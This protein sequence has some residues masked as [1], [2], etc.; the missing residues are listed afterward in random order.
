MRRYS[1]IFFLLISPLLM[2]CC[3]TLPE[4]NSEGIYIMVYDY[5]NNALKDVRIMLGDEEL[6]R[7]DIYGR[8]ILKNNDNE[9]KT[10]IFTKQGYENIKVDINDQRNQVLYIKLGSGQYYA[11]LS[12]Q[13][14]D[15][16][17]YD[18][19]MNYINKALECE[20]RSDYLYLKEVII[21]R[22]EK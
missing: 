8:Y 18:A 10:L 12:E 13:Y 7:T 6:G 19:A 21:S 2:L 17:K 4:E 5:E 1:K 22:C 14:L 3:K 9:T 15:E 16:K 11:A 20:T